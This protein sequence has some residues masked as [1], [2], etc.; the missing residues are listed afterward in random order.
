MHAAQT[1]RHGALHWHGGT[2]S[3]TQPR[4]VILL[5]SDG[6]GPASQTMARNYWTYQNGAP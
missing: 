6:F 5:V 2:D 4:N 1:P 3:V